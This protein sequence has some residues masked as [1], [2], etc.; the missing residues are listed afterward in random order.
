M[1]LIARGLDRGRWS[2][3]CVLPE[4]GELAPLLEAAG[5]EVV[6][7]PLAVLR[8]GLLSPRGAAATAARLAAD[9]RALGRLARERR[10]A[11]VHANTS[12][13]LGAAAAAR[14]AG[15]GHVVHV[16]E[17]YA[18]AAGSAAGRLW[19]LWRRRLERADALAC[20]SGATAAQF[21]GGGRALVTVLH[22]GLPRVM[23]PAPRA[24]AR[25]ALGLPADR[26][27]VALL[28]RISD[29]KGQDVLARALARPEL[30][31]V[32]AVGLVAGDAFPGEE[33]HEHALRA[34]AGELGLGDRLR[35]LGFR[36]DV[37]TVLGAA[38]AVVVPSTRPDPLPNSALEAAAAGLPLVA[39]AHGGLPEIVE[40]GVTGVLVPPG[41]ERALALALRALADDPA[42][43]RRLGAAASRAARE[44]F[45][46][47]RMLSGLQDLYDR[48]AAGR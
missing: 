46:P 34:L 47:E 37:E 1:L 22:D 21:D 30:A 39:A 27:A 13:V 32:G 42:R 41:D 20:V 48:V 3:V 14:A 6:V 28:G 40:D 33:R 26:F 29:W 25:A 35:L 24:E 18:G 15:A 16:R 43:A 23:V 11:V 12:V 9:R 10:A 36:D 17:I 4:R 8:R 45:A 2:P 5:A 44:R 7:R 19:P 38:D 31:D